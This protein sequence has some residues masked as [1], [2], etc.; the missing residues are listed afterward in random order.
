MCKCMDQ[1]HSKNLVITGQEILH[2]TS[3]RL[4]E[5]I[6]EDRTLHDSKIKVRE[7]EERRTPKRF[8]GDNLCGYNMEWRA[9]TGP[10][11]KQLSAFQHGRLISPF[12]C[13]GNEDSLPCHFWPIC[14]KGEEPHL[15]EGEKPFGK[16]TKCTIPNRSYTSYRQKEEPLSRKNTLSANLK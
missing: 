16:D 3:V 12:M 2:L 15:S 7:F 1:N 10:K 4:H 11:G 9:F 6:A 8:S 14:F 13:R 5:S